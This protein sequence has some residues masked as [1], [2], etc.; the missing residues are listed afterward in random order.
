MAEQKQT[1]K[2]L[3]PYKSIEEQ[4]KIL[5]ER[6]CVISD[7]SLAKETLSKINYYRFSAYFLPFKDNNGMYLSGTTFER[8]FHIYEFDRELRSLLFQAIECI[9]VTLRTRIARTH[10]KNC[11]RNPISYLNPKN[12]N[13]STKVTK[14]QEKIKEIISNNKDSPIIKH[15]NDSYGGK[16][17]LW[18]I[19]EFFTFGMLSRFYSNLKIKGKN[20]IAKQYQTNH[21][22]L[23]SW[24]HCCSVVRNI[25]AHGERL[26]CR[27]FSAVPKG[28][29]PKEKVSNS[30]WAMM[31]VIK[32]LYPFPDKWQ[33]EF[34]PQMENI[35]DKYSKDIDLK[36]LGFPKNWKETLMN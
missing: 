3:K 4:I 30:L 18:V 24:L 20:E 29:N 7:T 35:M 17:P 16:L 21:E 13:R 22:N 31:L 2:P 8:V 12:F 26:Y 15:H 34:M 25:C 33:K 27:T 28:F 23:K 36:H 10:V 32:S 1:I 14:F 19:I 11:N 6:H 9:E 5:E